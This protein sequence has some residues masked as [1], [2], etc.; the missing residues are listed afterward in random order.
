MGTFTLEE[1]FTKIY[2]AYL[3]K[4]LNGIYCVPLNLITLKNHDQSLFKISKENLI[5]FVRSTD[6]HEPGKIYRQNPFFSLCNMQAIRL[7]SK[8]NGID[9]IEISENEV[10]KYIESLP[11]FKS[12]FLTLESSYLE[13]Q[14]WTKL[15]IQLAFISKDLYSLIFANSYLIRN[16]LYVDRDYDNGINEL[17][18]MVAWLYNSL[19]SLPPTNENR[20]NRTLVQGQ[21]IRDQSLLFQYKK[22]ALANLGNVFFPGQLVSIMI[23]IYLIN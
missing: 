14:T 1:Y 7:P 23:G 9:L 17:Q 18:K 10:D 3:N 11:L 16:Y 5:N 13:C 21:I 8:I 6:D 12:N 20:L 19:L 15:A 4:L 2:L 22:H